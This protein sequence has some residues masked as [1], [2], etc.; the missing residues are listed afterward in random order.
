MLEMPTFIRKFLMLLEMLT[1]LMELRKCIQYWGLDS[2]R[3]K[4]EQPL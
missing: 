1:M 3:R 2:H 4:P